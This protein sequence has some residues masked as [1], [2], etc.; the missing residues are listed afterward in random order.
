MAQVQTVTGPIEAEEL[1][2]TLVH[3]HIVITWA[4]EQYERRVAWT[5][6]DIVARAVDK[7]AEL[8]DA[9]FR[10]F[11]DP[12]PIEL[13]RDPELYAEVSQKSG[14]HVVCTTGF[15]TEHQGWGL[16]TYWRA[17]DPEEIA[18]HYVAELR[19]GIAHTGGIRAGAIKA[20]TGVD[21]TD[22]E[23]RV[24]SG[25][26]LA[27]RDTGVAIITHTESSR[28]GDTQQ[29]IFAEHGADLSR[30]LIGHQDEQEDVAAIRKLAARGTFVGIDRIGLEVIA[31]DLR[32]ADH[33]AALVHEGLTRQVCLSQ[34]HI[35]VTTAPRPSFYVPPE[36]REAMVT[37]KAE[38]DWQVSDRPYTYITTDFVP[39][40]RER[41]VA[42]GDIETIFTDNPRRLLAGG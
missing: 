30:V 11:V 18:E 14:M 34:D 38:I 31:P 41:G 4:G 13:G 5:R 27:Q 6:A 21:V 2:R 24:L 9:G 33:V 25:A 12:C 15:Y 16:P 20:A 19:D 42:D 8:R 26:A 17:R 22:G 40:L 29:D 39:M 3:E 37:R 36:L 7:L 10:T 28:H 32:R 1:G 23:R 35:C